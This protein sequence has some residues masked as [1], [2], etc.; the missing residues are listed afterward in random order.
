MKSIPIALQSH[1]NLSATTWCYLLCIECVGAFA[2]TVV[3][4]TTLDE[5]LTY[6]AGGGSN[7]LGPIVYGANN[8]F[9]IA[10]LETTGDLAVDNTELHGWVADSGITQA[11]IRAGIFNFAKITIYRVNY[12]DLSQGHEIW[13][14]GLFGRTI[15]T[16]NR[17]QTEYRSLIQLLKEPH[18]D[19]YSINCPV[20]FGSPQC[21]KSF[22]WETYTVTGVDP[23][24]PDRI[25][26]ASA[27]DEPDGFYFLGVVEVLTGENAGAQMEVRDH[28]GDSNGGD[29]TLALGLPFAM[30]P[31]DTFRIREDCSKEWNDAV[32]GCLR[33]YGAD[34][35][36][37]H[38]GQPL[39]PTA[40]GGA[41]MVPGAQ[42]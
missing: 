3:G 8:S 39:I 40:D 25:F 32:H 19:L 42:L 10:R 4:S 29:L 23:T 21:G 22:V 12:M 33:H 9:S 6:D 15:Y 31:G 30:A 20:K 17:W 7:G 38:R 14:S 36:L 18:S 35:G 26:S 24:E 13:A 11:Q 37:H 34:R 2:G 1:F 27:M 5:S 41:M 28:A 16:R